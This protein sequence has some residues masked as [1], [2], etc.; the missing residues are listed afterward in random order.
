[1]T[2]A[3]HFSSMFTNMLWH[4]PYLIKENR[5]TISRLFNKPLF[6]IIHAILM[7]CYRCSA[8]AFVFLVINCENQRF[9]SFLFDHAVH[10]LSYLSLPAPLLCWADAQVCDEPSALGDESFNRSRNYLCVYTHPQRRHSPWR[11]VVLHGEAAE[12]YPS[13]LWGSYTWNGYA[14]QVQS[15]NTSSADP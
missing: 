12:R 3:S 4:S 14:L 1:M 11:C 2:K 6:F 15:I 9:F 10:N 13:L 8:V 5:G 7:C